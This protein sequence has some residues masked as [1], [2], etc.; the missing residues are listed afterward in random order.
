MK[1]ILFGGLGKTAEPIVDLLI[2]EKHDITLFD[3]AESNPYDHAQN[4][5]VIFGDICDEKAVHQAMNGI[6]AIIHLAVNIFDAQ[7]DEL[8]FKTNIFG[9]YN[10]LNCALNNKVS[11]I[12]LAS[13]APVHMVSELAKIELDY[14]CSAGEDFTYDLSKNLQE[15]I[16]KHFSYTYSMN[17]MVLRLGHIVDGKN[18]STLSGN[19]LSELSYCKGG[20]VCKYDVAR[21][22]VKAVE[23]DFCG[24]NLVNIS[25]SG[26]I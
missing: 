9:T 3:I 10:V 22:F 16:A 6:D 14:I 15:T 20:W 7:N 19:P 17:C 4:I 26:Y 18:Q 24:Y 8:T 23:T 13:S 25:S 11:K 2:Q 1:I 5:K 12:L 21:A